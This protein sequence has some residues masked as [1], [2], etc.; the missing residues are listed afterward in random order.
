MKT[1]GQVR[2]FLT[3]A[4]LMLWWV[5]EGLE[6]QQD[7]IDKQRALLARTITRVERISPEA[8]LVIQGLE[9]ASDAL[10]KRQIRSVWILR[11]WRMVFFA[12][13]GAVS[14]I[15]L[16]SKEPRKPKTKEEKA[17]QGADGDAGEAV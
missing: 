5:G 12:L 16:T 3:G 8:D 7:E 2:V 17:E 4:A 6:S 13:V 15:S 10:A 1:L 9:D 14:L 11:E